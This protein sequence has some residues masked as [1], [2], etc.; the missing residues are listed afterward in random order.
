MS[1]EGVLDEPRAIRRRRERAA[2]NI[3]A[4]VRTLPDKNLYESHY[5]FMKVLGYFAGRSTDRY[6]PN[7]GNVKCAQVHLDAARPRSNGSN[8]FVQFKDGAKKSL[9]TGRIPL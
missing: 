6:D 4:G 1:A 7:N 9:D 5:K 8:D 3:P 2:Q